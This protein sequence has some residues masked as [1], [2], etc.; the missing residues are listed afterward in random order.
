MDRRTFVAAAGTGFAALAGCLAGGQ[1]T[2]EYDVGMTQVAFR[3]EEV[4]VTAGTAVTFLNT[5]SH[6]HTVTAY[7]DAYP[8][9][10]EY[11]ASGSF[12]SQSAARRG[13]DRSSAGKLAPGETYEHTFEVPGR[14]EY[15]CIPHERAGMV[16]AV[17][18]EEPPQNDS[19]ATR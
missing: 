17:V 7:Q 6:S 11:W 5:S 19:T 8:E 4:T 3:P 1:S 2:G 9:D 10:A 16:G 18:V 15:F 14:Y 12:E 13:W